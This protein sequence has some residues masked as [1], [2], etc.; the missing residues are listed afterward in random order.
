[1]RLTDVGTLEPWKIGTG[2]SRALIPVTKT[3][4]DEAVMQNAD[5]ATELENYCSHDCFCP[6]LPK[7]DCILAPFE[8]RS[9]HIS[10]THQGDEFSRFIR[11]LQM[12]KIC[13]KL[14]APLCSVSVFPFYC[15]FAKKKK[16]KKK[17][18]K[19]TL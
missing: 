15:E 2:D 8:R 11:L 12:L 1:M 10:D 18:K 17:I 13:E 14:S 3:D 7:Q 9:E 16:N 4:G 5:A 19:N 6:L